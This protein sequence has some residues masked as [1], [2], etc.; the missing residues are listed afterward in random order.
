MST[1]LKFPAAGEF[2]RHFKGG[3]Y[4]VVA[5]A[6][7]ESTRTP[8]VVYSGDGGT[9]TRPLSE[10]ME[11]VS[12]DGYEGPRF[13]PADLANQREIEALRRVI[14]D[15]SAGTIGKSVDPTN[16]KLRHWWGACGFIHEATLPEVLKSLADSSDDPWWHLEEMAAV[17]TALKAP[18]TMTEKRENEP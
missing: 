2:W 18:H 11:T 17:E 4:R 7:T 13:V 12:R 1:S 14:R 9:W 15:F 8:V 16:G 6:K 10:F 3:I 5:I